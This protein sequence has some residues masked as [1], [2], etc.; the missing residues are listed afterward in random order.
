MKTSLES[1]LGHRKDNNKLDQIVANQVRKI[2]DLVDAMLSNQKS[3]IDREKDPIKK[4][5]LK[6]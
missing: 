6:V 2:F 5:N 4:R 3:D 1:T